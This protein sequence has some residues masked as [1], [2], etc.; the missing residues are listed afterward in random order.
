MIK[1][2]HSIC[3]VKLMITDLIPKHSC[4]NSEAYDLWQ[5]FDSRARAQESTLTPK[6]IICDLT[7]IPILMTQDSIK[8][9]KL[10]KI[11][12]H[13]KTWLVCQNFNSELKAYDSGLE[14]D[15]KAYDLTPM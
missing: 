15:S 9:T 10:K 13:D 3:T 2:C 1:T 14:P 8:T 4:L 7:Q 12:T 11:I 6:L 5:K